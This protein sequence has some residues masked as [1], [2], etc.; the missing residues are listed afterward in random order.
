MAGTVTVTK[1]NKN[2]PNNRYEW[3]ISWVGDSS[4]GSVPATAIGRVDGYIV[5]VVTNPGAVAPTANYDI[6]ITDS[7]GADVL[8]AMCENRSATLSEQITPLVGA[9]YT[10]VLILNDVLTFNLANN[11]VASA[12][13]QVRIYVQE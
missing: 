9:A 13:G 7:D 1:T 4:T 5:R 2:Y 8:G 6:T 3:L 11:S 12:T 10:P